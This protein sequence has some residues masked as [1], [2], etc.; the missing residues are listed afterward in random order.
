MIATPGFHYRFA[1][2]CIIS[3]AGL[4]LLEAC[5]RPD[6]TATPAPAV[7]DK[8]VTCQVPHSYVIGVLGK[9]DE[10]LFSAVE[11]GDARRAERSIGEGANVNASGSLKRTP[12]F[13]AAFCDRPEL[14]KLLIDKG[15]KVDDR[16]A[17]G[18]S[19]LHAAV[20]VGGFDTAKILIA[21]GANI[22]IADG[23]G[24]TPLHLAAATNQSSMVLM[25][26]E[27]GANASTRDKKG[28]TAAALALDNGHK[29]P[30]AAIKDWQTN[31]KA[32][33]QK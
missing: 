25:L 27:R 18:M 19:P 6:S 2:L 1:F 24:R 8:R 7:Q 31:E 12:L 11:D 29:T 10:E 15:G 28:M 14:A 20:I 30:A 5:G 32:A 9:N 3:L 13:A 16:D 33:R 23:A 22:N 17:N 26:L 21:N 4:G